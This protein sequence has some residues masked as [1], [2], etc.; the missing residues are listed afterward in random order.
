VSEWWSYRPADFLMFAPGTYWRLF[1]LHNAAWWPVQPAL[2]VAG[3]AWLAWVSR[4]GSAAPRTG[5]A[6]LALA[7]AFAGTAFVLGRYATINWAAQ[8]LATLPLGASLALALLATRP[9]VRASP[10]PARRRDGALLVA[11]AIAAHPLLAWVSGRP[12][13]QAEVIGLAPDP[14]AIATLGLLLA[15][16]G[17]SAATRRLRRAAWAATALW[18]AIAAATLWT[19][20]S[21][22]AA[23]PIAA[24]AVA[25]LRARSS[26]AAAGSPRARSASARRPSGTWR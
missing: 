10:L 8:A 9:D 14:T 23:V 25:A 1:E 24:L 16:T 6:G 4:A 20:G 21:T 13:A 3:L 19:M 18:C 11:W 2:I 15:T 17:T 22:Q 7:G 5:A 26:A 12:L